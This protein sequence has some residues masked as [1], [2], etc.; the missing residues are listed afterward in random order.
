M[1]E[2]VDT[3]AEMV[4]GRIFEHWV[5]E[6]VGD[7]GTFRTYCIRF[8]DGSLLEIDEHSVQVRVDEVDEYTERRKANAD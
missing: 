7:A 5:D 8:N 6:S 2:I 1:I 3:D 4:K